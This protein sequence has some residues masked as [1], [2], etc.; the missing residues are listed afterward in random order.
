MIPIPRDHIQVL[1]VEPPL[2]LRAFVVTERHH[3]AI[4]QQKGLKIRLQQ[5][6]IG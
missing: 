3:A 1:E 5:A 4:G 6:L 2:N